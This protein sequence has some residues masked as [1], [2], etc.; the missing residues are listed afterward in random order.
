MGSGTGIYFS[1]FGVSRG[2][3]TQRNFQHPLQF[4]YFNLNK[5]SIDI[6]KAIQMRFVSRHTQILIDPSF[7][8]FIL[9]L[10]V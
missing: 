1:E 9:N 10:T 7:N 2:S 5:I 8:A 3:D 6:V 4:A